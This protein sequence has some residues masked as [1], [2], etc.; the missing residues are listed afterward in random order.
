MGE[1][2][3]LIILNDDKLNVNGPE[4]G[5]LLPSPSWTYI[6]VWRHFWLL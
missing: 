3:G 4:S 1:I 2:F 5:L 6:S